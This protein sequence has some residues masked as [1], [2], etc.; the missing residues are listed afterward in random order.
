MLLI[1]FLFF[2]ERIL[3]KLENFC[4]GASLIT[5]LLF[6]SLQ[7]ILRNF[8][9]TG[10]EWGDI[11]IRHMVLFILFF[12]AS[13]STKDKRHLYMDI[14][15]KIVPK[16]WKPITNIFLQCFCIVVSFFLFLAALKFTQDE[17]SSG[18]I[19]FLS[20][21]AWY[22]IAIMPVGFGLITFRFFINLVEDLFE[23]S[24]KK[25][26]LDKIKK[27]PA[28]IDISLKVKL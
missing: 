15:G 24:G 22:F 26:L 8:F 17:Q 13:L 9:H 1:R 25:A 27:Q 18:E 11:F 6:A 19:I 5:L 14:A 2:I 21:P 4:L 12:G 3:S 28:E 23:F 16:S 7:V 20:V 10:I